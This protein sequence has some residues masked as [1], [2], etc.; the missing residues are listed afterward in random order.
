MIMWSCPNAHK[1]TYKKGL[2]RDLF[3]MYFILFDY[4][5]KIFFTVFFMSVA[6]HTVS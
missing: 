4:T 2:I 6:S 1:F 5:S 3:Y